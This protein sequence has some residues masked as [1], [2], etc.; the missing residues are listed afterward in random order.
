MTHAEQLKQKLQQLDYFDDRE[1]IGCTEAEIQALEDL[2][3]YDIRLPEAYK[4]F[5]RVGGKL[6]GELRPNE[7]FYWQHLKLGWEDN[8]LFTGFYDQAQFTSWFFPNNP[9][10]SFAHNAFPCLAHQGYQCHFFYCDGNDDPPVFFF[11]DS[12]KYTQFKPLPYTYSGLLASFVDSFI[13]RHQEGLQDYPRLQKPYNEFKK[14]LFEMMDLCG[15]LKK[16]E[17][18]LEGLDSVID[19]YH[20]AYTHCYSLYSTVVPM[21]S[22]ISSCLSAHLYLKFVE[23]G[24]P[25]AKEIFL[26][27]KEKGEELENFYDNT[28]VESRRTL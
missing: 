8:G 11:N 1:F 25:E 23:G 9:E 3:P 21:T 15:T 5:L 28:V 7:V 2:H 17:D 18:Q 13:E 6:F 22:K 4:D 14:R 27:F 19:D 26:N 24:T 16:Y 10:V 12:E 20:E